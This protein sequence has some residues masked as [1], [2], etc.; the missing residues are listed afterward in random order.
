MPWISPLRSVLMRRRC[1]IPPRK[2]SKARR[3]RQAERLSL[4]F[5][6]VFATAQGGRDLSRVRGLRP[7]RPQECGRGTL[8]ACATSDRRMSKLQAFSPA[9]DR[10]NAC[11][12]G[13]I[14][15]SPQH[16]EDGIYPAFAGYARGKSRLKAGCGQNCPPHG[17]SRNPRRG[18]RLSHLSCRGKVQAGQL[19]GAVLFRTG[20]IQKEI[21]R[22]D[23]R[24]GGKRS[25]FQVV[26]DNGLHP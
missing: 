19:P 24:R 17:E 21:G 12:C 14:S 25:D 9:F 6:F 8:R 4:E 11:P 7:R 18:A 20:K 10:L 26:S 15:C 22:G 16:R 13:F 2:K 23:L 1:T 5:H 3:S